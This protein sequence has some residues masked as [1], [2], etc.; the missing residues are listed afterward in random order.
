MAGHLGVA[1]LAT[2]QWGSLILAA[3]ASGYVADS[4][5]NQYDRKTWT[6]DERNAS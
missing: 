2:M 4:A 3:S 6:G 1:D 5:L